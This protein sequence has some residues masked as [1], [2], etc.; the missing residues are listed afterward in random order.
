[1]SNKKLLSTDDVAEMLGTNREALRKMWARGTI[2][3]P[4]YLGRRRVWQ[5]EQFER[6]LEKQARQ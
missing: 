3:V 5:R 2:P 6:W 4:G 1:M